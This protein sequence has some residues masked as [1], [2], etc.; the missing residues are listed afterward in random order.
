MA[1]IIKKQIL[2]HL[3]RSAS[4][5]GRSRPLAA[6]SR[7]SRSQVRALP[8]PL[9]PPTGLRSHAEGGGARRAGVSSSAGGRSGAEAGDVPGVTQV[10][11]GWAWAGN[12]VGLGSSRGSG[13]LR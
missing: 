5:R 2:K 11:G 13:R 9:A 4:A 8:V 3:S 6:G 1:G 12:P 10:L 7:V